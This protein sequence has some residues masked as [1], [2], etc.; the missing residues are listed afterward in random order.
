MPSRLTLA[1]ASLA[2]LPGLHACGPFFPNCYFDASYTEQSVLPTLGFDSELLRLLSPAETAALKLAISSQREE[3]QAELAEAQV[4]DPQLTAY[5]RENP[6]A[7]LPVEFQLYATGA[8]AWHRADFASAATAWLQLLAL[9][10]EQ[11]HYRSVWAAYMLGRLAVQRDT[12]EA[13]H[14]W[15]QAQELAQAGFADS[16]HLAT[17]SL[18]D[19]ARLALNRRQF[20]RALDLYWQQYQLGAP[21]ARSSLQVTLKRVFLEP[22]ETDPDLLES[23][24]DD[25]VR[26]RVTTAWFL[27]RGGPFQ[28]WSATEEAR[29]KFW[30]QAV[31]RKAPMPPAEADRWA[32]AAYASGE[33]TAAQRFADAAPADAPASEWVR[34]LLLLRG[35]NLEQAAAHLANAAHAFQ[36][37]PTRP[38]L[39]GEAWGGNSELGVHDS[40]DDCDF[41]AESPQTKLAGVRGCLALSR[42]QYLESLRIFRSAHHDADSTFVAENVLTLA[43]LRTFVDTEAGDDVELRS[44][45]ARRLARTGRFSDARPYYP[46]S[47]R[48]TLDAY[49]QSA[50]IGYNATLPKSTRAA[51]FW[52]AAQLLRRAGM[53]LIGTEL[54]PDFALNGGNFEWPAAALSRYHDVG[55]GPWH[56]QAGS[57]HVVENPLAPTRNERDRYARSNPPLHR[58]HYRYRA[59]ELA[60]LAAELSPDNDPTTATILATAGNWIGINDPDSAQIFYKTLVIRC[61]DTDL[62]RKA[63]AAHW[64]PKT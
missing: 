5:D 11:R 19:R 27:A 29:F 13:E 63:A 1:W 38:P 46:D 2:F 61:P 60:M 55:G 4:Y 59:A 50:Q 41:A 22:G 20:G 3:A 56:F 31:S 44:I 24:A 7:G 8:R 42:E 53:D 35:G 57:V 37:N 64:L 14:C 32:W 12:A 6:P 58:Y 51:A 26:R 47:V 33:W 40:D 18:G 16:R 48:P 39:L 36:V 21:S 10:P 43:E 54:E 28:P 34:A 52:A 17:A 30:M 23:F 9:P 45:L 25:S 15:S 62:G 49:V